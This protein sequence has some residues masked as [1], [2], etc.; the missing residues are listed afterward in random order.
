MISNNSRKQVLLVSVLAATATFG[1][2]QDQPAAPAKPSTTK[3]ATPKAASPAT[4]TKAASAPPTTE[5]DRL[6]YAIGADIGKRLRADKLDVDPETIYRGIKDG[7][8]DAP[9]AMTEEQ[10]RDTFTEVKT[11][12]QAKQAQELKE[13]TEKN[14]K[15]GAAFLAANKNKEGVVVLQSGLQYKVLKAGD[16]KKPNAN[17]TVK[18]NYQGTL[19]DGTEFD[20]SYKRGEPAEFPVS[21]V[22]KGWTEALQLMPV[23]SKWQLFIP[24]DLAYG[25][26]GTGGPIGP[27]AT[28]IFEVELLSI[29][30]QNAD[31]GGDAAKA[32]SDAAKP[33]DAKPADA[34]ADKK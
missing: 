17:D 32:G 2:A 1:F 7:F 26:R 6:S 9:L 27:N 12:R 3:P 28:L 5:K 18:C 8:A 21:G 23:G 29:K 14:E 19:I 24:P 31:K 20:S 16:G 30:D 11:E 13:V 4:A 34:P 33:A 25:A 15:E 22:I 10:I